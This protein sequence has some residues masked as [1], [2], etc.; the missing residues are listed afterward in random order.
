M[1]PVCKKRNQLATIINLH[2]QCVT[3]TSRIVAAHE[4]AAEVLKDDDLGLQFRAT[5]ACNILAGARS[6]RPV[7]CLSLRPLP[8]SRRIAGAQ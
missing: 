5:W 7:I 2:G 6:Q 3:C 1:C 4:H 8:T